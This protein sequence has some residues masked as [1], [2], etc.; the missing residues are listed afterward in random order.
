MK[1]LKDFDYQECLQVWNLVLQNKES[2]IKTGRFFKNL[3]TIH[4][5]DFLNIVNNADR[6]FQFMAHVQK[7]KHDS[8]FVEHLIKTNKEKYF[9][10]FKC[11]KKIKDTND[12]QALFNHFLSLEHF[13]ISSEIEEHIS[14]Q[15]LKM[16]EFFVLQKGKYCIKEI[17]LV[18]L[19][20]LQNKNMRN[21][22]N[23][24]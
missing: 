24:Y 16:V 22:L 11:C 2:K 7:N 14:N 15:I 1:K 17:E 18:Y 13:L 3:I 8:V 4:K 23:K 12:K 9:H 5:N 19:I 21:I 20:M 10:K 6:Y